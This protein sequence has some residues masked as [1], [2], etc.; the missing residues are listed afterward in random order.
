MIKKIKYI[1][2][3]LLVSTNLFSQVNDI[4]SLLKKLNDL[5]I[6]RLRNM[7]TDSRDSLF[8]EFNSYFLNLLKNE[9]FCMYKIDTSNHFILNSNS[10]KNDSSITLVYALINKVLYTTSKDNKIRIFSYDN[11]DGGPWHTYQSFLQ[12]ETH[13]NHCKFHVLD[14]LST[15]DME[16]GYYKIHKLKSKDKSYYL[17]FGFGTQGG[18]FHHRIIKILKVE[19]HDVSECFECYPDGKKIIILSNR[20]QEIGLNYDEFANEITFKEFKSDE[21][22]EPW[23]SDDFEIITYTFENNKLIKK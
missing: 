21:M 4:D 23:F 10:L 5:Q 3:L 17:L 13:N 1:F 11:L 8:T 18:G 12:F 9:E 14:T 22:I 6:K 16:V 2:V 19:N 15:D 7:S 20:S